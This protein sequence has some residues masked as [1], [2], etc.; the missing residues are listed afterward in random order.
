M[1]LSALA[2]SALS[3]APA[4]AYPSYLTTRRQ[5]G[6]GSS[7]SAGT[8][9]TGG[10]QTEWQAPGA[11]DARG[12]CPG[13]NTL[14]NHNYLPHDGKGITLPILTAAMKE[15]YNINSLDARIL[16]SQ[17]VRINVNY[18]AA[19]D[20]DL[21]NLGR[22]GVL[23]HD[24]SLSQTD[25]YFNNPLPFNQTVWDETS[26]YFPDDVITVQQLAN[27]RMGRLKTSQ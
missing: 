15:G 23:E 17:A 24:Y 9:T 27:A 6:S 7:T 4:Y 1:K 14:A 26:T 25:R 11:G 20:F 16:F 10:S 18:P 8:S 22:E 19:N 5:L 2:F 3:V 21:E 12:P 13:L